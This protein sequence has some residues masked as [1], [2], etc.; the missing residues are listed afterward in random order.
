M[1]L[2]L[3]I[4]AAT[5][6]VL[7]VVFVALLLFVPAGTFYFFNAWLLIALLFIPMFLLGVVLL[8]RSPELLQKRLEAKEREKTQKSVVGF[9][10][11][12][13]VIGFIIAGLDFR[14]GWSSVPAFIVVIASVILLISY[15]L[16]AE[17]MRENAYL[18]RT[19]KVQEGQTVIDR[20]MYRIVRHPMYAVT[21]VLFISFSLV[22]GSLW[23][24]LCFL[25]FI[26]LFV[27]RIINEEI[28]LTEKLNGYSQYCFKVKYRLIPFI[29]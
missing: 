2:R 8:W 28:L 21:L 24:F 18:S 11:M 29:W 13:F 14:F 4:N 3:A 9:S 22:L 1:K 19:V 25:C 20:G 6:F 15:L 23:S 7:G 27:V 26:P 5:K 10:G 17:V 16:Y 12:L